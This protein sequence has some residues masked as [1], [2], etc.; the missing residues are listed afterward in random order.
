MNNNYYLGVVVA[1]EDHELLQNSKE[2]REIVA[3]VPGIMEGILAY[4]KSSELDEPKVGDPVILECLDPLY[5]SYFTYYKLKENNFIGI[6][7]AGKMI[8]ITPDD[9]TIGIFDKDCDYKDGEI[10]E[11]KTKVVIDADGNINI[12]SAGTID[13]NSKGEISIESEKTIDLKA[14]GDIT[15]DGGGNTIVMKNGDLET[16]GGM[17]GTPGPEGGFCGIPLCPFTGAAHLTTKITGMRP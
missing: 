15:I 7:A 3:D 1:V 8:S 6:R 14:G 11:C 9:I 10:P 2:H 13:V 12:E 4:P 5:K 17:P 16:S